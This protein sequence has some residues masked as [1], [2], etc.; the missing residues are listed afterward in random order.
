MQAQLR[1]APQA[2]GRSAQCGGGL[3]QGSGKQPADSPL[4]G[5]LADWYVHPSGHCPPSPGAAHCTGPPPQYSTTQ[6]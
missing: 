4:A 3:T 5:Q 6:I 2:D 1:L